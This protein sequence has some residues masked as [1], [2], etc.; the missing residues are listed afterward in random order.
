VFKAGEA[1]VGGSMLPQAPGV[2]NHWHVYFGT[3]DADASA[4]KA[5]ELGGSVV[6]P[7]F[8]TPVGRMAVLSDPQGAVFSIIKTAPQG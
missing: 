6:V 2:A 7:P 8:D 4:A 5:T 1:M 3:D